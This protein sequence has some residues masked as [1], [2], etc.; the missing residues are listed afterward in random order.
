MDFEPRLAVIENRFYGDSIGVTGLLTG[1][2]IYT[3][4]QGMDLGDRVYLPANCLKDN[5][6]FLDDWTIGD[7][8][9]KLGCA[10]EP[11]ADDFSR[12]FQDLEN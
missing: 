6:L 10:V 2:D 9:T 4:L 8:S 3:Q 11:L 7:M 12:I 5:R 1:Q